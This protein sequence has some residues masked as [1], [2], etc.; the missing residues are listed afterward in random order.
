M[1][2]PDDIRLAQLVAKLCV[3][4]TA[5]DAQFAL[6][7]HY[8]ATAAPSVLD[9]LPTLSDF[10]RRC[11]IEFIQNCEL[12]ELLEVAGASVT[13][14]LI[15]LLKSEDEVTRC[16]VAETLGWLGDPLA[17]PALL[18]A[19]EAAFRNQVPL[20]WSEQVN[21][22][23]ALTSLGAR[24]PV[25]PP[26]TAALMQSNASFKQYWPFEAY[27]RLVVDLAA[28]DQVLLYAQ[29]WIRRSSDSGKLLFYG[30][31]IPSYE[32]DLDL[33][34]SE[35]VAQA[36]DAALAVASQ[37]KVGA[38]LVVTAEWVDESDRF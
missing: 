1:R 27:E 20:D 9:V 32:L 34:W 35:L 31:E 7:D 5:E 37:L 8:G 19:R 21:I 26:L 38:N 11:A 23:W 14:R 3:D 15:P 33:P 12:D 2:T 36:R 16:W 4:S 24:K 25:V 28:A 6:Q 17:I 13:S 18:E 30:K 10:P 22:R 29:L